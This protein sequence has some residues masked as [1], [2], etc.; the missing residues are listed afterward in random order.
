MLGRPQADLSSYPEVFGVTGDYFLRTYACRPRFPARL[1]KKLAT[2]K[3]GE[4]LAWRNAN[5]V[6]QQTLPRSEQRV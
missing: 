4:V 3:A 6:G 2:W 1:T 5:R